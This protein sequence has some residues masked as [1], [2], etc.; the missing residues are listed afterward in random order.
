[1]NINM[2]FQPAGA[3]G[4]TPNAQA[5]VAISIAAQQVD[6]PPTN[7]DNNAML[8][9]VDD[10]VNVAWS[11]GASSGLTLSNG[12][13]MRGPTAALFT[14]PPNVSQLSVIGSAAVG[15]FR[16]VVGMGD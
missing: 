16:V 10:A 5:S 8:V 9:V 15:N 12:V 14:L 13:F 1:M 6:L 4:T 2:P 11:Y 3:S 7:S